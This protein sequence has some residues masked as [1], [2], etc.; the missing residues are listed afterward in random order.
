MFGW[1]RTSDLDQER[2]LPKSFGLQILVVLSF[3][4]CKGGDSK[5]AEIIGPSNGGTGTASISINSFSPG[6]ADISMKLES[7]QQFLVSASGNG[8]LVY[9]WTLDGAEIGANAPSVTLEA[10]GYGVGNK[11][12]K[13][14]IRDTV[15]SIEQTW[16]VKVNGAPEIGSV[17]P[18]LSS[19]DHRRGEALTF[20][21]SATD[22]NS[23]TLT[24][25]WK[26]NGQEDVLTSTTSSQVW[27]PTS[28]NLGSNVITVDIYDGP[29]SDA[30]SYKVSRSWTV[31]V[32]HFSNACNRLANESL[33]G[34]SCVYSGIAGIG[35]GQNPL[36]NPSAFLISPVALKTT[37]EGNVFIGDDTNH[38]VWF[39]NRAS[40]PSTTVLGVIVPYNQ[41][42]V[43]VGVGMPL[44]TSTAWTASS[45]ALRTTLNGPYGLEWDGIHLY[46]SDASNNRVIRVDSTGT[47]EVVNSTNCNSPRGL[48]KFGNNLYIACFSSHR[49]RR[50]NTDDLT[51]TNFAGSG[52]TTNPT[53]TNETT[54][55]DATNG[56]L[57]APY[58]VA[59]DSVGDLFV[60]EFNGCR[61]RAFNINTTGSKQIYGA[62][63]TISQNRQRIIL[64]T[65]GGPQCGSFVAGEAVNMTGAAD[66]RVRNLRH[67]EFHPNGALVLTGDSMHRIS[68]INFSSSSV[69]MYGNSV[70][71]FSMDRIAGTGASG[72][73][74]GL[75][76]E[77]TRMN[78]PHA[79]SFLPIS[80][81][82]VYADLGNRR[83]RMIQTSDEKSMRI[84]GNGS[85][86]NNFNVG[87]GLVEVGSEKMN[88]P[89]GFVYD[90]ITRQLFVADSANHR[91]RVISQFGEVSQAAGTGA[92][93][94]GSEDF[95]LPTN[96]T[97]NQPKGLTL[98]HATAS[99]GGHLVWADSQ[100][101]RVR[102]W[103]RDSVER[104]LF[105]VSVPAG[106]V[107]TIGGSGTAGTAQTGVALQ[108]AFNQPSG[109]AYD[110]TYLYVSDRQNHCVKRIDA[111]GNLSV[112]AGVC[113]TS[114]NTNGPAGTGRMNA[115]EGLAYYESGGHRGILIASTGNQGRVRFM[116]LAGPTTLL[117]GNSI[118][119]GDSVIVAGGGGFHTEGISA[120]LAVTNGVEDVA[121]YGSKF[122]FVNSVYHNV[123]CV[124]ANGQINT[125][126]GS[127]QGYNDA[128][129]TM[130]FPKLP[131]SG[132]DFDASATFPNYTSQDLTNSFFL[133]SPFSSTA[134]AAS[135][136]TEFTGLTVPRS[137]LLLDESTL[138]VSDY[139]GLIRKVKI[140]Q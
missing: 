80:Q 135:Y 14:L 104:E 112:A 94:L 89:R 139:V 127:V 17:S 47:V 92:S 25:M 27:T 119:V 21:V 131:F 137:V 33:S 48:A 19:M 99:F 35:D 87:Q 91:I 115:P 76:A 71:G 122:C 16:N 58:G 93:G 83:L 124:G 88:Q 18:T 41:M 28:V 15:G 97:M 13:V 79:A 95:E 3:V 61:V 116:R 54:F 6:V 75:S 109:V 2:T 86:R 96:V 34:K 84:A 117:F 74:E 46:V 37:A 134:D 118:A 11:V 66:A 78:N 102:I 55:T 62:S 81:D 42:K 107:A 101:H 113:G 98:T 43:V 49:I 31:R 103:N 130:H 53:N 128:A 140:P 9:E 100:N 105:G 126:V 24:Y 7:T 64:G 40:N 85:Y 114:G 108:D 26:L 69:N 90:P 36:T 4:S 50:V 60:S 63:W 136:S 30:G 65:S 38:V 44:A 59:V 106:Q 39:W 67:I 51:G 129:N 1:F 5:F 110:G 23:D 10:S 70:A 77:D 12:L 29:I 111:D 22:P 68:A 56:T 133:P 32:N 123:R 82:M 132:E 8:T 120:S 20:S 138:L 45:K 57:N 52:G 121:A 72:Y 73:G 125:V